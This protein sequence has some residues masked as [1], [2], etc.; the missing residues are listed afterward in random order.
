MNHTAPQASARSRVPGPSRWLEVGVP[1]QLF[2]A[3]GRPGSSLPSDPGLGDEDGTIDEV[4]NHIFTL[5]ASVCGLTR[6]L[7]GA[8]LS[9]QRSTNTK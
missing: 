2:K 4:N 7:A 8:L 9:P 6:W 1:R 3:E 5:I